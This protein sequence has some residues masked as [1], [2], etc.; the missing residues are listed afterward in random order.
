MFYL[1]LFL[2][3]IF[4]LFLNGC[5][6]GSDN[7]STKYYVI[8]EGSSIGEQQ[9]DGHSL[10]RLVSEPDINTRKNRVVLK[11][12]HGAW[13]SE[14]VQHF[15]ND[16][17]YPRVEVIGVVE[18]EPGKLEIIS[19]R[20]F[21]GALIQ[22][23]NIRSS[24]DEDVA[25]YEFSFNSEDEGGREGALFPLSAA[26]FRDGNPDT[27]FLQIKDFQGDSSVPGLEGAITLSSYSI[28]LFGVGDV[29]QKQTRITVTSP[30]I[31]LF[32]SFS[33]F[34]QARSSG[35]ERSLLSFA[36]SHYS[37]KTGLLALRYFASL[38]GVANLNLSSDDDGDELTFDVVPIIYLVSQSVR[39]S[40]SGQKTESSS[41]ISL[42]A[43][44]SLCPPSP[45]VFAEQETV[46]IS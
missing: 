23:L 33:A 18:D 4:S 34:I 17:Q 43:K 37:T 29:Q 40:V 21:R 16:H 14:S 42:L 31:D 8:V 1:K 11:T 44:G 19:N 5:G 35:G 46:P 6:G 2:I 41:C 15:G 28:H 45:D 20:V 22:S 39:Y 26:I 25:E 10:A 9:L 3:F 30:S 13:L 36:L 12:N 38:S 27:R 24:E 32:E 7:N